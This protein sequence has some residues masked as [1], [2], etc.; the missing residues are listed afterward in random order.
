MWLRLLS[1][2]RGTR[3]FRWNKRGR[4][5]CAFRWTKRGRGREFRG[6][7]TIIFIVV[8]HRHSE[9]YIWKQKMGKYFRMFHVLPPL[10]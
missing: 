6:L 7:R 9:Q 3:A 4:G 1:M 10:V 8:L 2:W 5:T